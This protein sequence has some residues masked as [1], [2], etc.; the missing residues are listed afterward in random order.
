MILQ[1]NHGYNIRPE[2]KTQ[3]QSQITICPEHTFI[4]SKEIYNNN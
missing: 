3:L 4:Q 2:F 1:I